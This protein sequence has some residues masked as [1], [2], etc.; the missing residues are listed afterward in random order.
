MR[1]LLGRSEVWVAP[2]AMSEIVNYSSIVDPLDVFERWQAE[3]VASGA[4][5]PEAMTLATVSE[6][7]APRARTVLFRGRAGRHIQFFTNYE[8]RK[9]RDLAANPTACLLFHFTN[10]ARQVTIS[11]PVEKVSREVSEAY[12]ATRPRE[13]QLGAWA[14]SQSQRIGSRAELLER[15]RAV[16]ER[17]AGQRVPCPP[18]WGGFQVRADRVE[19]WQGMPGRLHDRAEFLFQGERYEMHLLCP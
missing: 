6:D 5:Y 14:S 9:G 13:S 18:H 17:F 2:K 4:P 11:G 7:G 16:E 19:L 15:L 10:V 3:W 8:S 12:F 1:C